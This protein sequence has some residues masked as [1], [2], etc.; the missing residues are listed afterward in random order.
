MIENAESNSGQTY[1]LRMAD[2]VT[3]YYS[4]HSSNPQ[5]QQPALIQSDSAWLQSILCPGGRTL[6]DCWLLSERSR[7]QT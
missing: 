4:E 7:V 2:I 6:N 3:M 5:V 1:E